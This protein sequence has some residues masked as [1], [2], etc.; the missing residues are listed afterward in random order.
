MARF[1]FVAL[2]SLFALFLVFGL[3]WLVRAGIAPE[4][5]LPIAAQ[6]QALIAPTATAQAIPTNQA[7]ALPAAAIAALTPL[8]AATAFSSPEILAIAAATTP[9]AMDPVTDPAAPDAVAIVD[10]VALLPADFDQLRVIDEVMAGLVGQTSSLPAA[11]LEQWVNG[12]L[13]WRRAVET[14]W[15]GIDADSAMDDFLARIGRRREE[16]D[17]ALSAAHVQPAVFAAYWRRLVVAQRF[18]EEQALAQQVDAALYI[19][20]LQQAARISFGPAAAPLFARPAPASPLAA[21]VTTVEP[22][23]TP[24][25]KTTTEPIAPAEIADVEP[26][27]EQRGIESGML[28]PNFV[29]APVDEGAPSFA[30]RDLRGKPT[31]LSFWTT[32]CTYCLRQTPVLVDAYGTWAAQGINFVGI[33]VQEDRGAVEPY[34]DQHQ[35]EYPILLDEQGAVAAAFAVQG[36]PTTYFLDPDNRVVTRHVGVLAADQ[37]NSYIQ[38]LAPSN[39][40]LS[41]AP[42]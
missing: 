38:L 31:V 17:S 8:P 30:L 23:L 28:A 7:A 27:Q 24:A 10:G 25:T 14:D 22:A 1:K 21:A 5:A 29:L 32:W 36:Y 37:L 13:V 33:N 20:R 41:E 11:I 42:P 35:I 19:Q 12:E 26:I 34:L 16:L 2:A 40:E 18:V 39:S 15:P 6:P 9:L 4:S 3:L